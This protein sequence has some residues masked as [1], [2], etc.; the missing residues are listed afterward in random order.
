[1]QLRYRLLTE[2]EA[3]PETP[4][5]WPGGSPGATRRPPPEYQSGTGPRLKQNVAPFG[6]P[7]AGQAPRERKSH[8]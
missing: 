5:Y 8:A 1:M 3:V 6:G 7:D 4:G 2:L